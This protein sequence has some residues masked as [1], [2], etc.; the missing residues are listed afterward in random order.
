MSTSRTL[1]SGSA[2]GVVGYIGQ[3]T[4]SGATLT[5][6]TFNLDA[7]SIIEFEGSA[8]LGASA[9]FNFFF[10]SDTT[11]TNYDRAVV[12]GNSGGAG[13]AGSNAPTLRASG[14]SGDMIRFSGKI[15]KD[16]EGHPFAEIEYSVLSTTSLTTVKITVVWRTTGTNVTSFKFQQSTGSLTSGSGFVFKKSPLI[17]L[18]SGNLDCAANPSNPIHLQRARRTNVATA[19]GP[20]WIYYDSSLNKWLTE[21]VFYEPI[22]NSDSGNATANAVPTGRFFEPDFDVYL[23]RVKQLIY[24]AT[25]N[26]GSNFWTITHNGFTSASAANFNTSGHTVNTF[27]D[28]SA[29]INAITTAPVQVQIDTTKTGAPGAKFL[30]GKWAYRLVI[31]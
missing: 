23:M 5:S 26:N 9:D 27:V 31:P 19:M 15:L 7:D 2:P 25:T 20:T 6:P 11:V 29:T 18:N 12:S 30:I 13:G 4:L 10:N 21:E 16:S 17:A 3:F 8:K 24:V 1:N 14:A 22:G 28:K